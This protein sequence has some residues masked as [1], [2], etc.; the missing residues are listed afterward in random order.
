MMKIIMIG[1]GKIGTTI[2]SNFVDEGHSVVAI[3]TNAEVLED[4]SNIYDVMSVCGSGTDCDTL[5]EAGVES[6]DL[7]VA[8][9]DSDEL[10]ML[11]CYISGK[12]GAEH[13][14]ARIRK[15]EYNMNSLGFLRQQLG[16]SMSI[17]PELLA[18]HEIY[19]ILRLPS[20]VKIETFSQ[21]NFEIVE[22]ILK[23]ESPLTGVRLMDIR[24][25]FKQKFLICV[26]QREDDI[27]IPDGNFVLQKG[28]KIGLTAS[29]SEI[30]K[31]M[32]AIGID[33]KQAKNI[34]IIGGSRTAYYLSNMLASSGNRV[35][36]I[37]KSSK[38]CKELSKKL[39]KAVII[40]GDGAKQELL[41]EEGLK[42][43][44]AFLSL[45]GL[46]E[47]NILMSIFASLNK[48]P[49][50][51]AKVNR[52]ELSEMALKL[53]LDCIISPRK[54]VSDVLVRYARALENSKGSNVESLYK[55]MD[56]RAEVLEFNV[57]PDFEGVGIQLKNL[58]LRK[59]ILIGGII[60]NKKALLP[61]GDDEF[62]GGD[63]VIVVASGIRLNDLS[64]ILA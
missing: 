2:L 46:D 26:V 30:H 40:N 9:T 4:I 64:D 54:I 50:A 3:D 16:L 32:R 6:C 19:N 21:R 27:Y 15:P 60:R 42:N 37:D 28:D 12:M 10:N 49:K 51:I 31:L 18:A 25:K 56:D 38:K 58:K 1:C 34:I 23:N 17:N 55:I 62:A 59:N 29:P 36:I 8:V 44:D 35:K 57:S 39:P 53:G 48:V 47:E 22:L 7:V 43:A 61:S 13:T 41:L 63:K 11:C 14:I 20:A 45:T 52:N 5:S 24:N 33:N